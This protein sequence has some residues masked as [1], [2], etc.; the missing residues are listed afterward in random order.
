MWGGSY[1]LV[2]TIDAT[3]TIQGLKGRHTRR[4]NL[5]GVNSDIW[6]LIY[7]QLDEKDPGGQFGFLQEMDG[8]DNIP[9]LVDEDE[10]VGGVVNV[11]PHIKWEECLTNR[12]PHRHMIRNELADS[13]AGRAT[14]LFRRLE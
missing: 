5:S 2:I 10:F 12:T 13:V 1:K 8:G 3:Y 9:D 6:Q 7:E 14:D 4:K 11:K